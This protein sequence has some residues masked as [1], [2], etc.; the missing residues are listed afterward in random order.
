LTNLHDIFWLHGRVS[1][2]KTKKQENL[3]NAFVSGLRDAQGASS[4]DGDVA[5]VVEVPE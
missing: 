2:G 5:D 4:A 3:L 1:K